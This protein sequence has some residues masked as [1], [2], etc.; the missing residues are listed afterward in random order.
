MSVRTDTRQVT[1]RTTHWTCDI[2]GCDNEWKDRARQCLGCGRDLCVD[3]RIWV[4]HDHFTDEANGDY[5][6]VVC[7]EC[8]SCSIEYVQKAKEIADEAGD[9]IEALRGAWKAECQSLQAT[10]AS[11]EP[12]P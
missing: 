4:Y 9:R 7:E 5:P 11:Q 3:H 1:E 6:P 10:A 2:A 8:K 12:T